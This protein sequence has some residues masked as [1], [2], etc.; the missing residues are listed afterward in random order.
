MMQECRNTGELECLMCHSYT[1]Q[2]WYKCIVIYGDGKKK[3]KWQDGV[4]AV[5][6]LMVGG[7][8]GG[9]G[10]KYRFKAH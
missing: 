8:K 6:G 9:C 4:S 5:E 7:R 3:K 10:H 2:A 1:K